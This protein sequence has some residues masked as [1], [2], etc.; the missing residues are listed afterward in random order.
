MRLARKYCALIGLF[1]LAGVPFLPVR[2]PYS[3]EV[4]GTLFPA[5]RWALTRGTDDFLVGGIFGYA[6]G[7]TEGYSISQ[8]ERG[9][10]VRIDI[11]P[12]VFIGGRVA[13]GDTV[14]TVSSTEAQERLL[15]Y[16]TPRLLQREN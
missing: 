4:T 10:S 7:M 8:F 1:V 11:N 9:E 16:C 5:R 2:S 6:T 15:R 12:D 3:V 14:A 13:V